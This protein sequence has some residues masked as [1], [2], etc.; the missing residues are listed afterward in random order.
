MISYNLCHEQGQALIRSLQP[1]QCQARELIGMPSAAM[2]NVHHALSII[3]SHWQCYTLF[4][5]ISVPRPWQAL[6]RICL[7]RLCHEALVSMSSLAMGNA[8]HIYHANFTIFRPWQCSALDQTYLSQAKCQALLSRQL[9]QSLQS[10]Q[11]PRFRRQLHSVLSS[12]VP[13]VHSSSHH[14]LPRVHSIR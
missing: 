13:Q 11:S 9:P 12:I 2:D 1:R 7:A 14:K 10:I 8:K 3:F 4:Q 6:V 5:D